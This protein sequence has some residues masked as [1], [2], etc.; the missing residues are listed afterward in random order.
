MARSPANDADI[1]A[2]LPA[3]RIRAGRTLARGAYA[4]RAEYDASSHALVVRLANGSTFSIPVSLI[5]ELRSAP[6]HALSGVEVGPAGLALRW[7]ELDA[8]L[9]VAGLARLLFGS[10]LLLTAAGSAGGRS[11]SVAKGDAAR[12]NGLKGG[13]PGGSGRQAKPTKPVAKIAAKRAPAA[14]A[15]GKSVGLP[16]SSTRS[17]GR[18]ND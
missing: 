6:R 4:E 8:D 17:A 14:A 7:D 3:A 9:S 16:S 10:R 11:R 15:K 1:L 12:R 13:R 18:T 2:Q 5:P